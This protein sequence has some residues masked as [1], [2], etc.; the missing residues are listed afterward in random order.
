MMCCDL[1]KDRS[2]CLPLKHSV[3][4]AKIEERL[5]KIEELEEKFRK[6]EELEER[7]RKLEER[8]S[9]KQK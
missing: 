7:L 6:L 2:K 3:Q 9:V 1:C 8:E 4:L 5:R